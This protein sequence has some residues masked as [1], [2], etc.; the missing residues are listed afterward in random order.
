MSKLSL[1]SRV[2]RAQMEKGVAIGGQRKAEKERNDSK[3]ETEVLRARSEHAA[4]E[5]KEALKLRTVELAQL[6]IQ[7]EQSGADG[8]RDRQLLVDRTAE[9]EGARK[10]I[11]E[12]RRSLKL[13]RSASRSRS[14]SRST[15]PSNY[16]RIVWKR[17]SAITRTSRRSIARRL[18][19]TRTSKPNL[20]KRR[21][22]FGEQK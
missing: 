22:L 15:T 20:S 13:S 6:R 12:R 7:L 19:S 4:N 2:L 14:R 16:G 9:L 5:L 18:R 3:A 21:S 17:G 10:M 11:D 1:Q 8:V